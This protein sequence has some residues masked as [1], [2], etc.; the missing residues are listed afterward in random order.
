MAHPRQE[1]GSRT[2]TEVTQY[3]Q[4]CKSGMKCHRRHQP[5]HPTG[6]VGVTTGTPRTPWDTQ[7]TGRV[8]VPSSSWL[9]WP[10]ALAQRYGTG[11]EKQ[12]TE[13]LQGVAM[14]AAAPK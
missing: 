3:T 11:Q 12:C 6:A 14:K 9:A 7:H 5:F 13:K 8:M 10:A 1:G 2:R 4:P